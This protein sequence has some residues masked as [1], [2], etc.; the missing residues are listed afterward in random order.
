MSLGS[1][2]GFPGTQQKINS[3]PHRLSVIRAQKAHFDRVWAGYGNDRVGSLPKV[4]NE[5]VEEIGVADPNLRH[6][7]LVGRIASSDHGPWSY[8]G[9]SRKRVRA[10][11]GQS[12]RCVDSASEQAKAGRLRVA[13]RRSTSAGTAHG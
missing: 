13:S 2:S 6:H 3:E 7:L 11:P 5:S 9:L 1:L 12:G 4:V 8:S 10:P